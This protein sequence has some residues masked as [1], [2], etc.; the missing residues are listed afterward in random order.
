M[1]PW[2]LHRQRVDVLHALVLVAGGREPLAEGLDRLAAGDPLLAPWARRLGPAL[3]SGEPV[4]AVLARARLLSRGEARRL[5]GV[6]LADGL[7][8]VLAAEAGDPRGVALVRYLPTALVAA[9]GAGL[10]AGKTAQVALFGGIYRE[11]GLRSSSIA[12]TAAGIVLVV[13]GVWLA[14]WLLAASAWLGEVRFRPAVQA[15]RPAALAASW[16]LRPLSWLSQVQLLWFPGVHL[17]AAWLDVIRTTA[18]AQAGGPDRSGLP[19]RRWLALGWWR[20]PRA[21][22]RRL[23]AATPAERIALLGGDAAA[24]QA[25]LADR[26]MGCRFLIA[27]AL[28]VMAVMGFMAGMFGPMMSVMQQLNGGL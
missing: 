11:V 26:M 28:W 1:I 8:G 10:I 3:R 20:M 5:E 25:D 7:D 19:W 21:L 17:A 6:D 22:R 18:I 27:A 12:E 13:A 4:P 2:P 23:H 15:R 24:A 14:Q 16:I 9:M